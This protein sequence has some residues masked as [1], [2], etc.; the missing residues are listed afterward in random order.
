MHLR[1][2]V[3]TLDTLVK[4]LIAT[5]PSLPWAL[6]VAVEFYRMQARDSKNGTSNLTI[7]TVGVLENWTEFFTYGSLLTDDSSPLCID[8]PVWVS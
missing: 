3:P 8:N 4:G 2:G 5:A 1:L 6:A 7:E